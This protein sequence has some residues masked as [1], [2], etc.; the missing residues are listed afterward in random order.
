MSTYL[1][2]FRFSLFS[3]S[4]HKK[5][6]MSIGKVKKLSLFFNFFIRHLHHRMGIHKWRLV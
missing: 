2:S 5:L 1:F 6:Y 3:I 4:Y